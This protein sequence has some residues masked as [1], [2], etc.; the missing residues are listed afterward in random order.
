MHARRR[1]AVIEHFI[2]HGILSRLTILLP[3]TASNVVG[4][5]TSTTSN[6]TSHY[7]DFSEDAGKDC[8]ESKS[9]LQKRYGL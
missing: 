5:V 6:R 1:L 7:E 8:E 4:T 3:K 2:T 9:S